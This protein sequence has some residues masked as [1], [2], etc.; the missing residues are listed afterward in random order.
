MFKGDCF[1]DKDVADCRVKAE[2]GNA[3]AQVMLA[4]MYDEEKVLFRTTKKPLSGID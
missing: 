3:D 4:S 1:R 2:Q